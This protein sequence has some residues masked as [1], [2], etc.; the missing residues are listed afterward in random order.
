MTIGVCFFDSLPTLPMCGDGP[1]RRRASAI[2]IEAGASAASGVLAPGNVTVTPGTPSMIVERAIPAA[3]A[4]IVVAVGAVGF[5]SGFG[6]LLL[7]RVVC[8][9]LSAAAC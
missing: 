4:P 2:E 9:F 3:G 7:A 8:A 1:P 5:A 6:P